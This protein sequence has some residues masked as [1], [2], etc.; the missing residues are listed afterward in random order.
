[1]RVDQSDPQAGETVVVSGAAGAVGSLVGQ[2]ARILGCRV[3]GIAGSEE[4]CDFLTRQL[5]FHAAINYNKGNLKV[6]RRLASNQT[7][8]F[9]LPLF[10]DCSAESGT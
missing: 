7:S 4:K 9:T 10:S 3:V 6:G 1:M 2:I 5:G 8:L